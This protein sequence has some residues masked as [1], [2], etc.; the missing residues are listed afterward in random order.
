MIITYHRHYPRTKSNI[1]KKTKTQKP[2]ICTLNNQ[3]QYQWIFLLDIEG[4]R[5]H[6]IHSKQNQKQK[7]QIPSTLI[8][9]WHL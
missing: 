7:E 5:L 3:D 6:L 8:L 4:I 2:A 9:I 1:H